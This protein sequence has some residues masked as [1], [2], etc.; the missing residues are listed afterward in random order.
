MRRREFIGLSVALVAEAMSVSANTSDQVN[1]GL[2]PGAEFMLKR[3]YWSGVSRSFSPRDLHITLP[4]KATDVIFEQLELGKNHPDTLT[5]EAFHVIAQ[6]PAALANR[7]FDPEEDP[8]DKQER[9]FADHCAGFFRG[10]QGWASRLETDFVATMLMFQVTAEATPTQLTL[11]QDFREERIRAGL[12]ATRGLTGVELTKAIINTLRLDTDKIPYPIWPMARLDG[13][14]TIGIHDIENSVTAEA[15]TDL[16]NSLPSKWDS[17]ENYLKGVSPIYN[18]QYRDIAAKNALFDQKTAEILAV[19]AN[20]PHLQEYLQEF[21]TPQF[22]RKFLLELDGTVD[23]YQFMRTTVFWASINKLSAHA[24]ARFPGKRILE[25][26][27]LNYAVDYYIGQDTP[28]PFFLDQICNPKLVARLEQD[29]KKG[30]RAALGLLDLSNSFSAV[31][32]A[33]LTA[34]RRI[35][36]TVV[37]EGLEQSLDFQ[38]MT[39]V[40]YARHLLRRAFVFTHPGQSE[41]VPRY[42][43]PSEL[44]Y[45]AFLANGIRENSAIFQLAGTRPLH[46]ATDVYNPFMKEFNIMGDFVKHLYL[47]FYDE[48]PQHDFKTFIRTLRQLLIDYQSRQSLGLPCVDFDPDSK[49]ARF[50]EESI[51]FGVFDKILVPPHISWVRAIGATQDYTTAMLNR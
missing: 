23:A 15:L 30:D 41:M 50:A 17:V 33:V 14:V 47:R 8:F 1:S 2:A 32:D 16:E 20:S 39:G 22:I 24:G 34:D 19:V 40:A 7:Y 9:D 27:A 13:Q 44:L 11:E 10:M 42:N 51:K 31:G 36:D 28:T 45:D 25:N 48:H 21:K 4:R 3:N 5:Q 37:R 18:F 26:R 43:D 49:I 12:G 6:K 35:S 29:A 46:S 38:L